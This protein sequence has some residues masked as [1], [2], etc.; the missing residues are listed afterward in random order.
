MSLTIFMLTTVNFDVMK[1]V[2]VPLPAHITGHGS[3]SKILT[4]MWRFVKV[5]LVLVVMK[6]LK[7]I[8]GILYIN[9]NS[10][11]RLFTFRIVF[12]FSFFIW[13]KKANPTFSSLIYHKISGTRS[14]V[15]SWKAVLMC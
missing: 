7:D 11:L 14:S 12:G 8:S 2:N 13:L 6:F 9:F 15:H 10:L 4:I 1:S 3:A 5:F